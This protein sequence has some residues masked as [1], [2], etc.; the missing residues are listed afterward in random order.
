MNIPLSNK[1]IYIA[2]ASLAVAVVSYM[3]VTDVF[4][5]NKRGEE[6]EPTP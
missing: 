6:D 4:D 3:A 2:V 1:Q 5:F